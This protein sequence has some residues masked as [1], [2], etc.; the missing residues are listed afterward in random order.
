MTP[1]YFLL[2]SM[3]SVVSVLYVYVMYRRLLTI[4]S[5]GVVP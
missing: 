4:D 1:E 5:F 2:V 3:V